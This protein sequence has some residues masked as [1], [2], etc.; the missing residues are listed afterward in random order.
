MLIKTQRILLVQVDKRDI[1]HPH[2]CQVYLQC[3]Y[4]PVLQFQQTIKRRVN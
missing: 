4:C 3:D 1:L 2:H